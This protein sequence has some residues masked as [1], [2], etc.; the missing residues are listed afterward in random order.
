MLSGCAPQPP[1]AG[2]WEGQLTLHDTVT[3]NMHVEVERQGDA[4]T[5]L[6]VGSGPERIR[7]TRLE[8]KGDSLLVEMPVFNSYFTLHTSEDNISGTWH[9][10]DKG[11][12]YAIPF[13]ARPA[14]L[15]EPWPTEGVPLERFEVHFSPGTEKSYPAVGEFRFWGE[16]ALG[17]FVTE[18][19][20]Y[21]YLEG[22]LINKTLHLSAFDGAHAFAFVAQQHE[23]G[24]Y[25]GTFYSGKHFSEPFEMQ[26]NPNFQLAD[27]EG[28]TALKPGFSSLQFAFPDTAGRVIS[29]SDQQFRNKVVIVQIMGSWCPNCMDE[30][31]YFTDIY[32]KFHELGLEIVGL[33]FEHHRDPEKARMAVVKMQRDL[34][35]PYPFLLAG[36]SSKQRA[37]EALPM[38]TSITSFPTTVVIDRTG[39]VRKIHTGF[40]GPGTSGYTEFTRDFKRFIADLLAE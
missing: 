3:L 34:Q 1:R 19:G 40:S 14:Q 2:H 33:A 4:V 38:L 21:R 35:A 37:S 15:P 25:R 7:M 12:D 10:P 30:T 22:T 24:S 39:K 29:S 31:R 16:R 5:A 27:P 23:D 6:V 32:N 9:Y 11:D 28:L 26:P 20:D 13:E 36:S 8:H 17:T 18:T